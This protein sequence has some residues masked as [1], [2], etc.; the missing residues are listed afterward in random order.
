VVVGVVIV[1]AVGFHQQYLIN[2]VA[3][4]KE[5]LYVVRIIVSAQ[6]LPVVIVI[7]QPCVIGIDKVF[8][9]NPS[10]EGIVGEFRYIV[11][12]FGDFDDAV[13]VVIFVLVTVLILR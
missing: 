7:I 9:L 4:D 11:A 6:N 13:L 3:V 2:V 8:L 1:V 12:V 5:A 10:A